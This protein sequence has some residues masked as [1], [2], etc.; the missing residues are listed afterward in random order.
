MS[1]IAGGGPLPSRPAIRG[2]TDRYK[3]MMEALQVSYISAVAASAGC[4][5]G[6][7]NI[8]DGVDALLQHKSAQ[9]TSIT[10]R[11]ARLEVQL[12]ATSR[13]V[14]K[15]GHLTATMDHDRWEYYR[16]KDPAV[17]KIIVVMSMPSR[18]EHWTFAR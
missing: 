4:I 5:V 2:Y 15:S 8:D 9:H 14:N 10:D 13:S 16:T 17:N 11:V 6:N 3:N 18:Q 1:H 7:L 12:K